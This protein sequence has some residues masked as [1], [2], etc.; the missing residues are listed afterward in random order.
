MKKGQIRARIAH[1]KADYETQSDPHM[2]VCVIADM[3]ELA[4]YILEEGLEGLYSH[5]EDILMWA[6]ETISKVTPMLD[7]Y[8]TLILIETLESNVGDMYEMIY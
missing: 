3:V 7:D 6:E 5:V 8:E 1:L 2:K 4:Q